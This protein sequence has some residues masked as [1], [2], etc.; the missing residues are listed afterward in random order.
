MSHHG[1]RQ[2]RTALRPATAAVAVIVGTLGLVVLPASPAAARTIQDCDNGPG[3]PT[4][5]YPHLQDAANNPNDDVPSSWGDDLAMAK[6][7]CYESD[8]DQS[9]Y[10]A[11]GPYYGLG[12]MGRPAID[13]ANVSFN[14]YWNGG[15]NK[16]RRYHQLLGALRYAKQRYG[17]PQAAWEHE[18]QYGWW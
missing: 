8:F 2:T 16:N 17:S 4:W 5:F 7:V 10:N 6:I 3:A 1:S 14:C 9:A 12:Q 18:K 11:S 15:C 13:A